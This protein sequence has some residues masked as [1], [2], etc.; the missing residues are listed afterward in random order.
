MNKGA[1]ICSNHYLVVSKL[2]VESRN[3]I[4]NRENNNKKY[5][6]CKKGKLQNYIKTK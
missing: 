2:V 3:K 5:I 6:N 4:K 1:E